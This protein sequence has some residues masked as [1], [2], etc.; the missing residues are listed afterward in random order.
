M[1]AALLAG[2]AVA[3]FVGGPARG[4]VRPRPPRDRFGRAAASR[5]SRSCRRSRERSEVADAVTAH[6]GTH[7][8]ARGRLGS[9]DAANHARAQDVYNAYSGLRT[10]A[11]IAAVP[12]TED[13]A[14]RSERYPYGLASPSERRPRIHR[15][16]AARLLFRTPGG[17]KSGL[18][19]EGLRHVSL[20]ESND[21][22]QPPPHRSLGN[23]SAERIP[24]GTG[25]A[26]QPS[27]LE[28]PEV[29]CPPTHLLGSRKEARGRRPAET[30]APSGFR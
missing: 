4:Q 21:H 28:S 11:A 15:P 2:C 18:G 3:A 20:R 5:S 29:A 24:Y 7:S 16:R 30:L 9:P 26:P 6:L 17:Q 1:R 10:R 25:Q 8:P 12:L 27:V 13:S 23:R 14:L 22:C 19:H